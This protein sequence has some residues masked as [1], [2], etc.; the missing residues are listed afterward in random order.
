MTEH[1]AL[2]P[3]GVRLYLHGQLV[4]QEQVDI[5]SLEQLT[6]LA[7]QHS[8]ELLQRAEA[9]QTTW[10]VEVEVLVD[11][12]DPD[13]FLRFGTDDAG[14]REPHPL[15]GPW[16]NGREGDVTGI[17]A[18]CGLPY[19]HD[20]HDGCDGDASASGH[21]WAWDEGSGGAEYEYCTRC[22]QDRDFLQPNEHHGWI[23]CE[24]R[25]Q[26][27]ALITEYERE[28]GEITHTEIDALD[29]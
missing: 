27:R 16:R 6:E 2:G 29:A 22:G 23:A 17:G 20:Q 21:A 1:D 14:M 13:R 15:F 26:Q 25:E 3:I 9:E 18:G 19:A 8:T 10:M 24:K 28:H 7:E 12:S 5:T 11:P 4:R